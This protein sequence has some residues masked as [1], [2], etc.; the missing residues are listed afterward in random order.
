MDGLPVLPASEAHERMRTL[1]DSCGLRRIQVLTMRAFDDPQ[2]GGAEEHAEQVAR[3]WAMAGI[4]VGVRAAAVP[5]RPSVTEDQGV[6]VVRRGGPL[7]VYPRG[8]LAARLGRDGPWDALLEVSHGLPFWTPL[9]TRKPSV[10]FVHHVLQGVWHLQTAGGLTARVG[11][12]AERLALPRTYRRAHVMAPSPST[13]DS[14]VRLG[15]PEARIRVALNGID[16]RFSPGGARSPA[17]QLVAVGRLTPQKGMDR[18]LHVLAAIGR[19]E[20]QLVVVG[21][22]RSRDD[23]EQLAASLGVAEQVTFAGRVDDD[24]LVESYRRA[25][26]VVSASHHEGW[27][28]TLTEAAACGTPCVATRVAGHVDAVVDGETGVLVDDEE[29]M[30][31]VLTDLLDDPVRLEGLSAAARAHAL[32]LRW[33]GVAEAILEQLAVQVRA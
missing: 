9:W 15:V 14:L 31:R 20:V 16:D 28:L 30:A 19:P 2:R 11:E 29:E 10:L 4:E 33:D 26:L 5:G 6:R 18:L 7:T 1:A 13:R 8:A 12:A 22:G 25:W 32:T 21:E 27:G 3:H 17:P 24:A 23:L